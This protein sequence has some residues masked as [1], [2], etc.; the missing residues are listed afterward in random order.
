MRMK[1]ENLGLPVHP[2]KTSGG[3]ALS[4]HCRRDQSILTLPYE[5]C[6]GPVM[7][8]VTGDEN[9]VHSGRN[10]GIIQ[11]SRANHASIEEYRAIR[12]D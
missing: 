10:Q 7:E 5:S 12:R 6:P 9:L 11:G 3:A 2:S 1:G 8:P 4:Q